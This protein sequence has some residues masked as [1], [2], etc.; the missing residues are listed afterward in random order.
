MISVL[1]QVKEVKILVA[2][3]VLYSYIFR[4]LSFVSGLGLIHV[5]K[6][7]RVVQA[8]KSRTIESVLFGSSTSS[9]FVYIIGLER[10]EVVR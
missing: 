9:R 5:C 1:H 2:V 6:G 4:A 10:R 3:H 8:G 7:K